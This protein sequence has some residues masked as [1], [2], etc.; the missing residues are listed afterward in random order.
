MINYSEAL[1]YQRE[2]NG[3]SQSELARAT[4][5]AQPKISYYESGKHA[6]PIDDCI[7][8]ADF[9]G[10]TLDELVGRD[11]GREDSPKNTYTNNGIH[12]GNNNF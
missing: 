7:T 6:P 8:L 3:L 4:K 1:K 10:I 2:I 12:N 9:Y 5:I 11:H